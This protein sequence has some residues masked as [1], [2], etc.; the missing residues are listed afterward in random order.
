MKNT[1]KASSFFGDKRKRSRFISFA[2]VIAAYIIIEVMLKTG[3][4]SSLFQSLL[5]PITCSCR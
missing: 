3:N 2:L 5:V 4:L 1:A